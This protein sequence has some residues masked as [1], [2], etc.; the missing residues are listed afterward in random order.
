MSSTTAQIP[1]FIENPSILTSTANET[2]NIPYIIMEIL[3]A[4]TAS[5]G[6]L[7]VIIIFFKNKKLRK[8]KNF[9][10]FSL[11]LADLLIGIFGVAFAIIISIG[12][13]ENSKFY[14]L[15]VLSSLLSLCSISVFCI[16]GISLDRYFAILYPMV[17]FIINVFLIIACNQY[18]LILN[19]RF[20]FGMLDPK[21]L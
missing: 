21:L 2:M 14:C 6:N 1:Q 16:V 5:T 3:V 7:L 13:P 11:A 20:I 18:I 19:F 17:S 12:I 9:Y 8:Q 10:I 4:I 15:F